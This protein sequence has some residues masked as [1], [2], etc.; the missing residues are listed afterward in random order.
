MA[1]SSGSL[2]STAGRA[3]VTSVVTAI[4]GAVITWLAGWWPA[5]WAAITAAAASIWAFITYPVSLPLALV[6]L[7]AIPFLIRLVRGVRYVVAPPTAPAAEPAEKPLTTT[8][9]RLLRLF[10]E[11]DGQ[12]IHFDDMAHRLGISKLVLQ[13]ICEALTE[14]GYIKPHSHIVRGLYVEL[15]RDG[16]DFLIEQG[17]VHS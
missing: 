7:L 8:E 10:V 12:L 16:R 11:A 15:T 4:T 3:V 6:A 5:L 1:Q 14:R 2:S 13:Q 17:F 9:E